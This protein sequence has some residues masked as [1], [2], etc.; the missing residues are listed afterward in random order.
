LRRQ[1]QT[2]PK[3]D[4]ILHLLKDGKWHSVNEIAQRT[5]LHQFKLEILLGFMA[6]YNF[7]QID[8][9]HQK[10]KLSDVALK[11]LNK[12]ESVEKE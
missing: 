11:F 9:N 5:Q 7:L 6:E 4:E 12:I 3:T 10:A 2:P 1:Y 8:K